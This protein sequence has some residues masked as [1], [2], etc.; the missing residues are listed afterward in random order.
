MA[1]ILLDFHWGIDLCL[2]AV[3]AQ[4]IEFYTIFKVEKNCALWENLLDFEGSNVPRSI[5]KRLY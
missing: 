4:F 5:N 2:Y 1:R 3:L